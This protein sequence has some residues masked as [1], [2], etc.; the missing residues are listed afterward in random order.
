MAPIAD[1]AAA[2]PVAPGNATLPLPKKGPPGPPPPKPDEENDPWRFGWR[3]IRR[4]DPDGSET[5]EQVP[6]TWDDLL[7]PEEEDFVVQKP[8]HNRDAEYLHRA[9]EALYG[10]YGKGGTVVVLGDCRVDWGRASGVRPLGPD[11]LVL[12]DVREWFQQGT[13]R[14]DVEGGRPIVVIEVASPSTRGH[15]FE[16]KPDLYFRAGVQKYI[17]I[18]RGPNGEDPA[19]LIGFQR[20]PG[21]WVPLPPDAQGRLDLAPVAALIGLEG[22]RPWIYD[23]RTKE[24]VPDLLEAVQ[25]KKEADA[26]ARNEAQVRADAEAKTRDAEAKTRDAEA[27]TRD[28][29]AKAHDEAERRAALEERLRTLEEQ[30]RS[31]QG[32]G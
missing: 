28:A 7:Y 5:Y 20:G 24:R 9:L 12:F 31:T 3:Y 18:D 21:G 19:R 29:E 10:G 6:L 30:L 11:V 26:R 14:I 13:F 16:N 15:D 8:P 17:L 4:T 22:N 25:A 27:K 32:Q 2:A 23:A 1:P